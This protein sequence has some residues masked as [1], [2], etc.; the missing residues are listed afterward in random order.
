MADEMYGDGG[1]DF[2]KQ[3]FAESRERKRIEAKRAE[4]FSKKLQLLDT[5]FLEIS[6]EGS[7]LH[8]SGRLLRHRPC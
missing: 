8:R 7:G 3:T 4:D 1:V 5:T 6:F 2:A